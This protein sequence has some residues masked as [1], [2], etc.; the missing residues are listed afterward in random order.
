MLILRMGRIGIS[1]VSILEDSDGHLDDDGGR[2][3]ERI[4]SND[5]SHLPPQPDAT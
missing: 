2:F 4:H 5:G 3:E 1:T